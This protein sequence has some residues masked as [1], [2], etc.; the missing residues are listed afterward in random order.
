SQQEVT[1]HATQPGAGPGRI[2]Y[3]DLNG[4]G[5]VDVLDQDFL[6]TTLPKYIY[7]IRLALDYKN[8]DVAIFGSGVFSVTNYDPAKGFN[9][10]IAPNTNAGPGVFTAWTQQSP[11]SSIPALTVLNLNNEGRTSNYYFVNGA[12]FKL[13]NAMLGYTLPKQIASRAF[14]QSLRLYVSGQ[15]LFAIKSGKLTSKDPERTNFN[16]WPVPTSYTVGINANF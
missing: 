10:T 5:K 12:F 3:D 13:R 2:R 14:M 11:G 6:G 8:F 15:N 9:T 1:A 16:S 4:D 7:G